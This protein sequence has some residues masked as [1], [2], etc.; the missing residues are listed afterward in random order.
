MKRKF[1]EQ[2]S[3]PFA[4]PGFCYLFYIGAADSRLSD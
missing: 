4:C 3:G 1:V 2:G